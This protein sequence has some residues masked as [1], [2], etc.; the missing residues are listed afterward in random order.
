MFLMFVPFKLYKELQIIGKKNL[1]KKLDV[2]KMLFNTFIISFT[3]LILGFAINFKYAVG[4]LS[5]LIVHELGHYITAKFLKLNVTFGGFTPIGAY[6]THEDPKN[7]KENALIAL[8]GPLLGGILGVICY[9]IYYITGDYTFLALS[10]T[11]ITI[12]LS[13][14]IPVKPLDGGHIVESISPILCYIG[15]PFLIYLFISVNNLKSK[16]ILLFIMAAGAYQTYNF[17]I[18]YKTDSYYKVDKHSKIIFIIIYSLLVLSLAGSAI[19]IYN[20]FDYKCIFKNI[21]RYK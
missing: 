11:A 2:R 16:V 5:I 21:S 7:C 17:T 4:Y 19:Y 12:N 15:F 10:F 9:I 14:L 18:K 20:A 3:V 1:N 13:N 8:G 6:I